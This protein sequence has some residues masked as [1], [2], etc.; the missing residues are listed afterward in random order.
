MGEVP[1]ELIDAVNSKAADLRHNWMYS[2]MPAAGESIYLVGY[3]KQCDNT[4]SA[5][6]P[7]GVAE[8]DYDIGKWVTPT[9]IS[10]ANIPKM[11]CKP[12][13]QEF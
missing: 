12:T 3:C 4:V 11:G 8:I 2:F 5:R 13:P 1:Q 6:V 7:Y 9:V 10:R